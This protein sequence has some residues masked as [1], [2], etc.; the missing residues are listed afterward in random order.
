MEPSVKGMAA[1]MV[2]LLIVMLLQAP[3]ARFHL[4]P[5]AGARHERRLKAVRCKPLLGAGAGSDPRFDAPLTSPHDHTPDH[6]HDALGAHL[7]PRS[8]H[9]PPR[10]G[11]VDTASGPSAFHHPSA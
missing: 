5:E 8:P 3:N 4:R 9:R 1:S 10:P 2:Y 6:A 11:G 7:R